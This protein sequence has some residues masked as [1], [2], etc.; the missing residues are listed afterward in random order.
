MR[1]RVELAKLRSNPFRDFEIDP[2][3]PEAKE[4]LKLSIQKN[5]FWEGTVI[6][7]N[8][9]GEMEVACGHTQLLAAIDCGITHA[10]LHVGKFDDEQMIK[11]YA[12][13]NLTQRGDLGS[14]LYGAIGS[15]VRYLI[16]GILKG[17]NHV[18]QICAT[19][20][21]ALEIIRGQIASEKGLGHECVL[22]FFEGV[23]AIHESVV[24]H[25]LANLKASGDYARIVK[26]VDEEIAREQAE[27]RAELEKREAALE[28]A[29]KDEAEAR[30]RA[31]DAAG[32]KDAKAAKQADKAAA[33]ASRRI[34]EAETKVAEKSG[35]QKTRDTSKK[36]TNAAAKREITFDYK[37]VSRFFKTDHQL[38]TFK[39]IL[40]RENVKKHIPVSAQAK[41]AALILKAANDHNKGKL[42][43]EW[44]ERYVVHVV[45]SNANL[46]KG[47]DLDVAI[48]SDAVRAIEYESAKHLF[49]DLQH[50]YCRHWATAMKQF[51][52]M[53]ELRDKYPKLTFN[54]T[55][56]LLLMS[57]V[58]IPQI[59]RL[60]QVIK[61]GRF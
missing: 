53:E 36:A 38:R 13:E 35:I 21:K 7:Q 58:I 8:K 32:Q 18:A 61:A 55:Q 27:E 57:Q 50:Q 52:E 23:P 41:L 30:S 56:E 42:N 37:G 60:K 43:A 9:D 5:E 25:Q 6:R 34:A 15:A 14:A 48:S 39:K 31:L 51:K 19:S 26:E 33:D 16:K 24:N 12:T 3:D 28:Q 2:I 10:D 44:I 40:E 47:G 17:D 45:G 59:E 1:M 49:R 54:V 29:K 46:R 4:R 11:V 22:R 20:P